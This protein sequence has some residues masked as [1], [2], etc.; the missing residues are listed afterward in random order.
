MVM[1]SWKSLSVEFTASPTTFV[2]GTKIFFS[3]GKFDYPPI[4]G[5]YKL[6]PSPYILAM[7][8]GAISIG[9]TTQVLVSHF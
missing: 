8:E 3:I 2:P 4:S 9:K 7:Q 6:K 1:Q 5:H